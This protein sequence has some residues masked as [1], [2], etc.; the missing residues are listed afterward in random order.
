M[1]AY[2]LP[3]LGS[4]W[5]VFRNGEDFPSRAGIHRLRHTTILPIR[6][7]GGREGITLLFPGLCGHVLVLRFEDVQYSH[8]VRQATHADV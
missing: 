5:L 2:L 7:V 1:Q 4:P 3:H 8:P 6:R